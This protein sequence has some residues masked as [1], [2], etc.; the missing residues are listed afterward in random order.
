MILTQFYIVYSNKVIFD[1][2]RHF[3]WV[4]TAWSDSHFRSILNSFS[5]SKSKF[6]AFISLSIFVCIIIMNIS[7]GFDWKFQRQHQSFVCTHQ[8]CFNILLGAPRGTVSGTRTKKW[9]IF[10][11]FKLKSEEQKKRE[12]PEQSTV[13]FTSRL[14]KGYILDRKF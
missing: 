12:A 2:W 14:F 8:D 1:Q 7:T 5:T 9:L 3:D 10:D 11:S 13:Y 4:C 6:S